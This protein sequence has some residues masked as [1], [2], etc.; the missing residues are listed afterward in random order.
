MKQGRQSPDRRPAAG[1]AQPAPL[2]S[3]PATAVQDGLADVD[4]DRQQ[5]PQQ[6]PSDIDLVHQ[7][8]LVRA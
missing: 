1:C 4:D 5:P 2:R 8:N 6:N 7:S 3:P